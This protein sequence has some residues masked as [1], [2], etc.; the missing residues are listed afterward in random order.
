MIHLI[1]QLYGTMHAR[2]SEQSRFTDVAE[3]D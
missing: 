2:S 3:D 1:S